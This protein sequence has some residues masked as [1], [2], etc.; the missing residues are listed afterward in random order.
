M[1]L[2]I[3]CLSMLNFGL[4]LALSAQSNLFLA[5]TLTVDDGLPQ[6]SVWC[7]EQDARGYMWFGTNDGLSR[8]DG[9]EFKNYKREP[10][11]EQTIPHNIIRNLNFQENGALWILAG[12]YLAELNYS[13]GKEQIIRHD[14]QNAYSAILD[15]AG[16]VWTIIQNEGLISYAPLTGEVQKY[17][18]DNPVWRGA[19][20]QIHNMYEDSKSNIW[21][22]S[23]QHGL[24][25][26]SKRN[27]SLELVD[28][29]T[30]DRKITVTNA[31]RSIYEDQFGH[32]WVGTIE[33]NL[34]KSNNDRG[35][36]EKISFKPDFAKR[37]FGY[38]ITA[39]FPIARDSLLIAFYGL[40][41]AVLDINNADEPTFILEDLLTQNHQLRK[42]YT[43]YQDRSGCLWIGT[44]GGVMK[45]TVA[46]SAFQS[47]TILSQPVIQPRGNVWAITE[48]DHGNLLVGTNNGLVGL[49]QGPEPLD[50]GFINDINDKLL[51]T[52]LHVL[53]NDNEFNLWIASFSTGILKTNRS[54]ILAHY[55]LSNW[56]DSHL[57]INEIYA[58]YQSTN[59]EMWIGVN[60][61]ETS[62]PG[63]LQIDESGQLVNTYSIGTMILEITGTSANNDSII[64]FGTYEKGLLAFEPKNQNMHTF[65]FDPKDTT[66]ISS[67]VITALYDQWPNY[68]WIGT[69]GG[70]LNR[71][72]YVSDQFAHFTTNQGL[73]DNSIYSIE[74]DQ[75]GNLWLGTSNG[76]TKFNPN[77]N[78]V[79]NYDKSSGLQSSEFNLGA[80]Y[81]GSDGHLYFGGINGI[82]EFNPEGFDNQI[83]PKLWITGIKPLGADTTMTLPITEEIKIISLETTNSFGV[84][85]IGFH[86]KNP[87]RN[88]CAYRLTGYDTSWNFV[89]STRTAEFYNLKA[90]TYDFYLKAANSDSIW[91]DEKLMFRVKIISSNS[92]YVVK[93]SFL[94]LFFLF[95]WIIYY[96]RI[97]A[98]NEFN[99]PNGEYLLL[100]KQ[101]LTSD[102]QEFA[103]V[104]ISKMEQHFADENFSLPTLAKE[105][106][107]SKGHL[108]RKSK[109]IFGT[110]PGKVLIKFRVIKAAERLRNHS[111][112]IT[113]ISMD[114][115]FKHPAHFAR[116]FK[117]YF[118]MS[119]KDYR[120]AHNPPPPTIE[121]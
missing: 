44:H 108:N 119:P 63:I 94:V 2:T 47:T 3:F 80:S 95:I 39:I 46:S 70:G 21:L 85:Y 115:G 76:L 9:Y 74:A 75:Q 52:P 27:H 117:T 79:V 101:E 66:S 86:Y 1:K 38:P 36:F 73:G 71:Y 82:T 24:A 4:P 78:S 25:K 37:T 14:F 13:T 99:E 92:V 48:D 51:Q 114:T 104:F 81:K 96:W 116:V 40:G 60:A 26:F 10:F 113:E 107:I 49:N 77:T 118:G 89:G 111:G 45:F 5:Q 112:N 55:R 67:N 35:A 31:Q 110:P 19:E 20:S 84:E 18:F 12:G 106:A 65:V 69:L 34:L 105:L 83:P 68:L 88:Q 33:G 61:G 87:A 62:G 41:L 30:G 53:L 90:G 23:S 54:Q 7:I 98:K 100:K 120:S 42:I 50:L 97:R 32:L 58:L 121:F 59:R 43:I 17:S 22:G 28:N 109:I 57:K 29:Q 11:N 56:L 91:S 15:T 6:N 8:Y 102:E 16:V 103:K 93:M 72:S 64:W